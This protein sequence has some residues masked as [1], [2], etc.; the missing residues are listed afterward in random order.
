M[1]SPFRRLA[2]IQQFRGDLCGGRE[3]RDVA[4]KKIVRS[5]RA[6]V[7]DG[8]LCAAWLS[9]GWEAVL[10]YTPLVAGA[11]QRIIT[12]AAGAAILSRS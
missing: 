7:R 1:R 5:G 9:T 11:A 10:Y 2:G 3:F 8:S 4:W 6:E 12:L